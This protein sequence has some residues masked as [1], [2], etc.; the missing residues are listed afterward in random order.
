MA[1]GRAT[2]VVS[3]AAVEEGIGYVQH[4]GASEGGGGGGKICAGQ[5]SEQ[6]R[7]K[8]KDFVK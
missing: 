3:I 1:A 7:N 2:L 6:G 8:Q 4:Y 5:S